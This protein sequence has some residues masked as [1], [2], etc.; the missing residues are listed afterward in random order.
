MDDAKQQE[1]MQKYMQ[2][3]QLDQQIKQVQKQVMMLDEQLQ[4]LQITEQALKEVQNTKPGTSILSPVSNGIFIQ[5]E[6]KD[7][8][9]VSINVGAGVVVKKSIPDAQ[10]LIQKQVEEVKRIH[11]EMLSNMQDLTKQTEMLQKEIK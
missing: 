11:E 9:N 10:K 4:D 7:N 5:S 3:Q 1:Q 6:F 8:K 2:M